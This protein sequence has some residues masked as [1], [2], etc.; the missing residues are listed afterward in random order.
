MT[1]TP[2]DDQVWRQAERLLALRKR[3]LVTD[4]EVG[5]E[6]VVRLA[7]CRGFEVVPDFIRRL[8]PAALAAAVAYA[9]EIL[10]PAWTVVPWGVGCPPPTGEAHAQELA[11]LKRVAQQVGDVSQDKAG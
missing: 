9:R 4:E 8:S 2:S 5:R 11:A 10:D 7:A 3:E 6:M 1:P